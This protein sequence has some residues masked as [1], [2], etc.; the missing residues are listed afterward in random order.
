[1]G[2]RLGCVTGVWFVCTFRFALLVSAQG[3]GVLALCRVVIVVLLMAFNLRSFLDGPSSS[4]IVRR[5]S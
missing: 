4:R 3:R 5:K 2:D 1:M